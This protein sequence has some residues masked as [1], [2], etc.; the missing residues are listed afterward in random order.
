VLLPFEIANSLFYKTPPSIRL[1]GCLVITSLETFFSFPKRDLQSNFFVLV[2]IDID[3]DPVYSL[4]DISVF[5]DDFFVLFPFS[6]SSY[7]Q[8]IELFYQTLLN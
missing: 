4:S 2:R 7:F 8:I 1:Q 6:S 3:S 5:Y